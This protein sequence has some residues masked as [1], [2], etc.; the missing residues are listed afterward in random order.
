MNCGN[1]GKTGMEQDRV[2][3]AVLNDVV[4]PSLA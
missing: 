1:Y 3:L 2:N 4:F